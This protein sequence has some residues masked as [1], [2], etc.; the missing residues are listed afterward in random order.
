MNASTRFCVDFLDEITS[1]KVEIPTESAIGIIESLLAAALTLSD[2]ISLPNAEVQE[3][4]VELTRSIAE[5]G[6]SSSE[7]VRRF[8]RYQESTS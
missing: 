7:L 3:V 2:Q 5:A 8:E 6:Q 4:A 1:G